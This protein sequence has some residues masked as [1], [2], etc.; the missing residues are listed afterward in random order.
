M[1]LAQLTLDVKAATHEVGF[2]RVGISGAA[3]LRDAEAAI[4]KRIAGGHMD[5]LR[6][7][8]P[9]RA[10]LATR[11]DE[12]LPGAQSI[13]ALAA[14]YLGHR[15]PPAAQPGWPRGRIA[16]YAWGRD[17]HDV[18][19]DLA[20]KLIDRT[21]RIVG[22]SVQA[23]IF[24]D[25]SP[26]AERAVAERAGLGW[27]GKNT[28][29]L[30]P[31]AG[32]WAFLCEIIVDLPLEPDRPVKKSCGACRRCLDV[33]PTGAL[34]AP[35]VLDNR[36]CISFLTIEL[37]DRIPHHLRPLMGNWIFGCDDCQEVCP[38][39]RRALPA[40]IASLR[41]YDDDAA[42]PPLLP[43]LAMSDAE[44][45]VRHRGTPVMRA[46]SWGLQ[47]NACVALGNLRDPA[48]IPALAGALHDEARFP[49]VREHA[50]WAL[51]R[52]AEAEP[53]AR[54]AL[55]TAWP[56]AT[57]ELHQEIELALSGTDGDS[58]QSHRE[59]AEWAQRRRESP[60]IAQF[61]SVL[62]SHLSADSA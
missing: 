46:K 5:G 37:K 59:G 53:S 16:R 24:V 55:E 4:L 12:L 56:A 11:P 20:R 28:M 10:R 1:S 33:C 35:G 52:F 62:R 19:K 21:E 36:R 22:R 31:G 8:T 41:A 14:S 49:I 3:P 18:L 45:R 9:E 54:R 58:P 38:V 44:F 25:S 60:Q 48:A 26:L 13:I 61:D 23:R 29:L 32:S 17:Y 27:F 30:L 43:L 42:H 50:A 40:R 34:V 47:R 2:D 39:N 57:G 51:G 15:P 6:W 7:F